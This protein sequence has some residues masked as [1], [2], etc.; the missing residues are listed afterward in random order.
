MTSQKKRLNMRKLHGGTVM[1][2]PQFFLSV[3]RDDA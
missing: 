2:G 3:V 1:F